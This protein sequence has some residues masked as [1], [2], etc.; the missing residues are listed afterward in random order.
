[1]INFVEKTKCTGCKMCGDLCPRNAI[2]FTVDHEGFWYPK[3]NEALCNEC[4]ICTKKCPAINHKIIRET[5]TPEVYAAW[6]KDREVRH[7]STSGGIFWELAKWIIEHEGVVVGSVYGSDWKSAKHFIASNMQELEKVRGSKYF[8]SD[9]GGIYKRIKDEAEKG[10]YVLVSGTPCQIAAVDIYLG[11]TY[12]NVFLM[13]FICRSINSPLAFEKYISELE[14]TYKSEVASIQLKN[15]RNGWKSL[16]SKVTFANGQEVCLDKNED[17]WVKGF[18]SY[19]L[20]GRESCYDCKYR[21][22]PRKVADITVGDFWGIES[23]NNYDMF[24]GVSA[25]IVNTDRGKNL[26]EKISKNLYYSYKLLED[27]LPGNPALIKNPE[28]NQNRKKFFKILE[29]DSFSEAVRKTAGLKRGKR[30]GLLGNI[31]D[32]FHEIRLIKNKEKISLLL[33]IYYNYFSKNIVRTGKAKIIPY[34]NVILDLHKT[35]KIY[36]NGDKD[37]EIGINK[38]KKSR[39]ETRVRMDRDAVWHANHGAGLFY[40]T[41]LEIKENAVFES[42]YFTANTGSVII[43]DSEIKFGEDVMLGRN[44]LVYDSDFHQILNKEGECVNL[45]KKVEI[46]DHVWLTNNITVLKGV[47]IGQG[48]IV[49]GYTQVNSCMPRDTLISAMS[50]GQ[51]IKTP[52]NWSREKIFKFGDKNWKFILFGYGVV[53]KAFYEQYRDKIHY[54]VDNY[55]N[56]DGIYSFDEFYVQN[57]EISSDYVWIIASPN[58]FDELYTQVRKKY[59]YHKII[60]I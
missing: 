3:V 15:K 51:A 21:T 13:D 24:E 41:T 26:F 22:I 37:L 33:Y 53:G 7:N 47:T 43:V 6:S 39:A 30:K 32:K 10:R 11:K 35:A 18:I 60:S 54:V 14:R 31:R 55:A 52:V 46:E 16:A 9:T 28:L 23:V 2:S 58:H 34:K 17:W 49:A 45:P 59:P 4:G 57:K 19:D 8:Q 29:K 12:D 48:S 25:I 27:V 40:G 42:G 50:K 56:Q 1:M 20:Y 38:L 44:I 5:K 36:V